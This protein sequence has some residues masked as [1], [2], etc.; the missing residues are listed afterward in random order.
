MSTSPETGGI[1]T[2]SAP[3]RRPLDREIEVYGL[4]HRGNVRKTNQDHFLIAS[5][6]KTMDVHFTSLP[7]LDQL[8]L[9][10]ENLAFLGVV[11]DGVGSGVGGDSASRLALE[12]VT[13]YVAESMH[14]Y[15]AAE[16]HDDQAFFDALQQAALTCHARIVEQATLEPNQG[17][18][19]TTLTLWLSVWPR[20]YILQVG[21][22]RSYLFRDGRLTQLTRDQTMAEELIAQGVLTRTDA[23]RTRWTNVLSSAIGGQQTA[24]VVTRLDT[25]WGDIGLM[26]SDGL[27]KHVSDQRIA[28]RLGTMRSARQVCE[29]LLQDALDDGGTDNVTIIVGRAVHG[30]AD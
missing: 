25:A 7:A 19:A 28:E 4:T 20:S 23:V 13:Q 15:Y 12:S 26:C 27:T 2:A 11:A 24:P 30:D 9:R 21:D 3:A 18:M 1:P 17:R 10:G 5:L 29:D 6:R 8:P 16:A 22:S 14:C